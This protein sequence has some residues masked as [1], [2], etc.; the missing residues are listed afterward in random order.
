MNRPSSK[1]THP[2]TVCIALDHIAAQTGLTVDE[3]R[4]GGATLFARLAE[5]GGDLTSAIVAACAASGVRPDRIIKLLLSFSVALE[6][7]EKKGLPGQTS[8]KNNEKDA[9]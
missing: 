5:R 1:S 3:V 6:Q 8:P 2:D 4:S 9:K 7:S